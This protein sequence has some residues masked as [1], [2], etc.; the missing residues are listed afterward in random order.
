MFGQVKQAACLLSIGLLGIIGCSN[1]S[2]ANTP[3]A[4]PPAP[5]LNAGVPQ[6]PEAAVNAVLDGL[7]ASKPIVV[8][9]AM[10]SGHQKSLNQMVREFA[11]EVDPEIWTS[12]VSN[13]KKFARLAETKKDFI[14]KSPLL[15][16]ASQLKP[17]ELKACWES[18]L[19]LLKTV[20][21]SELVDQEKMRNFDGREFLAGTG[22]TLF[23]DA[24]ALSHT[25]KNDPLKQIDNLTATVTKTSDQTATAEVNLGG[26]K[27]RTVEIPLFIDE[28][29]W[30]SNH[31][32]LLQYV[33]NDRLAPLKD[34]FHPYRV[35]DW[36]DGY[37]ADMKR[38]DKLLDHLQ[39]AKTFDDFQTVVSIQVLPY[40]LQKT[41][42][43]KQKPK[44]GSV[45]EDQSHNRPKATAMVLVKGDHFADEPGMLAMIKL[46]RE[47]AAESKGTF[48]G[49]FKVEN[50]TI[51]FVSPVSDTK[52]L[53][54]KIHEG[55]IT[56]VDVRKNKIF[57]ELPTSPTTDKS[58]ADAD[59]ASKPSAH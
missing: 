28:G 23:A 39:A 5:V 36:K 30:T 47:T 1:A 6:T 41:V 33:L 26:P 35:I 19:N 57:I 27:N 48:S 40:V 55:K 14:L 15:A 44:Q 29:K 58:T 11:S 49:P 8:W 52:G 9:D 59:G 43:L 54:D 16:G 4:A 17:D 32:T 13:L 12:T 51:F 20:L 10:S 45:L 18:G 21:Q 34:R 37:L 24:R 50:T 38:I 56:G 42:Q 46:F 22:A 3:A 7:K 25:L 31:F 53:A 2:T